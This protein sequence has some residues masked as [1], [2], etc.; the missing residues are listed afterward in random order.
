MNLKKLIIIGGF[1]IVG[2]FVFIWVY[3]HS[4]LEVTS[5]TQGA[6]YKLVM[7]D[8]KTGNKTEVETSEK[9][10]KRFVTRGKYQIL[11]RQGEKSYVASVDTGGFL[12]T[13]TVDTKLVAENARKFVGDNPGPCLHY[14]GLLLYS[15]GCGDTFDQAVMHA[16]A[17]INQPT[18]TQKNSGGTD[19]YI[20][21]FIQIKGDILALVRS[22]DADEEE[23]GPQNIYTINNGSWT[24]KSGYILNKLSGDTTYGISAFNE[25][26]LVY[27][28]D[29]SKAYYYSN[30]QD[31]GKVIAL[32]KPSTTGAVF[33]SLSTD[34]NKIV[35]LYVTNT[36]EYDGTNRPTV[37][38]KTEIIIEQ[39]NQEGVH[40]TFNRDF[41]SASLCGEN[42]LCLLNNEGLF[43]YRLN[44]SKS[45]LVNQFQSGK[46]VKEIGKRLYILTDEGVVSF[47]SAT[48]TGYLSYSFASYQY[49]GVREYSSGYVLCLIN[50]KSEKVALAID[51]NQSNTSSIDKKIATLMD[52]KDVNKLSIYDTYIF[53]S[54][55]LGDLVFDEGSH[56]FTY[57]K[58]RRVVTNA[59]IQKEID[60]QKIN[61][62]IYHI[63]NT[64]N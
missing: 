28:Q 22:P 9:T 23:G 54:P 58:N 34:R 3:G 29:G 39:G 51:V 20:E 48:Q 7:T 4:Y 57:D 63:I 11:I 21:G 62:S 40:Y 30:A 60:T 42:L 19:G 15:F 55:N 26:F 31:E 5:N 13:K 53:I 27:S 52:M 49:C 35:A 44:G 14:T 59:A 6:K 64:L 2:L 46:W 38:G 16:P 56:E 18:I 41:S 43:I 47:D 61:R 12:G 17:T 36:E 50:K 25:G 1:F 10:I 8:Q 32:T 24:I 37:K 45:Q 33:S